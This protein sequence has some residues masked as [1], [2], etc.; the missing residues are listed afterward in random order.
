MTVTT[1][2]RASWVRRPC[3]VASA[4][5]LTAEPV[6]SATTDPEE[7]QA[8]VRGLLA[9]AIEG[10]EFVV[11]NGVLAAVDVHRQEAA[12]VVRLDVGPY[13]LLV[14]LSATTG[15]FV[16]RHRFHKAMVC[17]DFGRTLGPPPSSG[18]NGGGPVEN[19]GGPVNGDGQEP[20][21]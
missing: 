7:D 17:D 9:R 18:E 20:V 10:A 15:E 2:S 13:L 6:S 12:V 16:G 14:E 21:R 4:H 11:G 5:V 19:G 8:A 1:A 3:T